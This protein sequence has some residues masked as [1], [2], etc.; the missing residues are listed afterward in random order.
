M[1]TKRVQRNLH[2]LLKEEERKEE[3]SK[4]NSSS[5]LGVYQSFTGTKRSKLFHVLS[6]LPPLSYNTVLDNGWLQFS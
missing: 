4:S 5:H 1:K 3:G 2:K 6:Q